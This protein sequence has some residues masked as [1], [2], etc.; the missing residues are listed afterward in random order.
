ML[1]D[2]DLLYNISCVLALNFETFIGIF[3]VNS[4]AMNSGYE[5]RQCSYE[6]LICS[7]YSRSIEVC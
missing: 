5:S 2:C 1:C 6:F 3:S 4:V 7:L